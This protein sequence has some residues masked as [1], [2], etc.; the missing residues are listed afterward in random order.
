MNIKQLIWTLS[1]AGTV[2]MA[3]VVRSLLSNCNKQSRYIR[4]YTC[5]SVR[6]VPYGHSLR[7]GT[8]VLVAGLNCREHRMFSDRATSTTASLHHQQSLLA[9]RE[10]CRAAIESL[11][12][13]QLVGG[14]V[15]VMEKE[16]GAVLYV[17]GREYPLDQ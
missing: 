1:G 11:S 9:G 15:R 5:T 3:R 7:N 13:R 16:S 14:N 10:I 8:R 12:P 4:A 17:G 2:G 6:H